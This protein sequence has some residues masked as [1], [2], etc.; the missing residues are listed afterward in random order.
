MLAFVNMYIFLFLLEILHIFGKI[1]DLLSGTLT[2]V[3]N[4][5]TGF[6]MKSNSGLKRV[7][8]FLVTIPF[9]F[10]LKNKKTRR[11]SDVFRGDKRRIFPWNWSGLAVQNMSLVSLK[12]LLT[13]SHGTYVE[14][15]SNE[16]QFHESKGSFK[17]QAGFTICIWWWWIVFA[18]WLA[19][20][21]R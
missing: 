6:C 11:L 1:R 15:L 10:P 9:L 14:K 12:E 7:N 21:R 13:V 20:E 8:P 19:D 2:I 18:E 3:L 4:Q 5:M 16:L 17:H